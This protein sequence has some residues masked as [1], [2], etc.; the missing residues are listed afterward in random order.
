MSLW[1]LVVLVFWFMLLFIWIWLL[2][3]ILSD[4]FRDKDLSGWAKAGWTLFLIV[5]PWLGALVY[6]I[7]RGGSMHER[8]ME[9]QVRQVEAYQKYMGG[10]APGGAGGGAS[11]ADELSKLVELR[12]R[13]A[14]ST[15]EFDQAKAKVLK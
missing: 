8:A 1:D 15:E 3:S 14:I 13:G 10:L 5:V 9:H 4:I 12:D 2:I 11:A 7:A 6:L